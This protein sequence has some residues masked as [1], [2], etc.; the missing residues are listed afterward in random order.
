MSKNITAEKKELFETMPVTKAILTLSIPTIISQII[1]VIYNI[2]DTFYV[3]RTGNPYMIAGVS[4]ALPVFLMTISMSNLFGIGGGSLISRMM[5]VGR[6]KDAKAVSSF[7]FYGALAVSLLYSVLIALFMDPIL[8]FLGASENTMEF[9]RQYTTWVVVFGCPFIVLSGVESHLLRNTGYSSQAS[10]GL[11]GGGI[12]NMILDP[13]FMFVLFPKGQEVLAA[14][15]AT[16]LSNAAAFVFLSGVLLKVSKEAPL[17]LSPSLLK[18][19]KKNHV[20]ETFAVGIPSALLPGLFDVAN[21]VMNSAMSAH[22]DLQLAAMGIVMKVERFPN[23]IGIGIAQGMLPLVAYNF[24][25]GDKKRMESVISTARKMGIAQ[26]VVFVILFQLF[27]PQLT[28]IFLDEKTG[29][30][31]AAATLVFAATFLKLRGLGSPF[32]FINFHSSYSMQAMGNGKNTIIHA[33]IRIVGLYIPLMFLLDRLMGET[34][35]ALAL[36]VAEFLSDFVAVYL[37]KRTVRCS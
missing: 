12:L 13:I 20:R 33:F 35:L 30:E 29:A 21:I 17:S 11:S 6:E 25:S 4:L 18:D 5:G 28:G 32:Q 34:G 31:A 37:L 22:G 26:G 3:G 24:S 7:S 2:A 19:V 15:V 1:S 23:A 14:A 9:S 27:A 16:C 10:M 8:T 36:P